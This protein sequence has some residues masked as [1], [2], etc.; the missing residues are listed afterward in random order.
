[1]RRCSTGL[2]RRFQSLRSCDSCRFQ[3]NRRNESSIVQTSNRQRTCL[4]KKPKLLKSLQTV[5][6]MGS[7]RSAP[8]RATA[9]PTTFM[10]FRRIRS[11]LEYDRRQCLGGPLESVF[12]RVGVRACSFFFRRLAPPDQPSLTHSLAITRQKST[13][14]VFAGNV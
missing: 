5:K 14:C 2:P 10:V 11:L 13:S 6:G 4:W 7:L 1:V 9:I 8:V 12:C 3:T